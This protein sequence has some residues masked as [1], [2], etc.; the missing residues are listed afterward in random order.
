MDPRER[1]KCL[2]HLFEQAKRDELASAQASEDEEE[3]APKERARKGNRHR[4]GGSSSASLSSTGASP[5]ASTAPPQVATKSRIKRAESSPPTPSSLDDELKVGNRKES[6]QERQHGDR[7]PKG[8]SASSASPSSPQTTASSSASTA[9]L[10]PSRVEAKSRSKR[11]KSSPQLTRSASVASHVTVPSKQITASKAIGFASTSSSAPASLPIDADAPQPTVERH[12]VG[13]E[14]SHSLSA[15]LSSDRS[16]PE[17]LE[18]RLEEL[19]AF[20]RLFWRRMIIRQ[21]GARICLLVNAATG[22][23]IRSLSEVKGKAGILE[24]VGDA[25]KNALEQFGLLPSD[26]PKNWNRRWRDT[27]LFSEVPDIDILVDYVMLPGVS[28]VGRLRR[29]CEASTAP[30]EPP[31]APKKQSRRP[32]A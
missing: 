26:I 8:S 6:K 7:Q 10:P 18:S 24:S 9:P 15:P 27:R 31:T 23:N 1:V 20:R 14:R 19:R 21:L 13:S 28:D 29:L 17:N 4:H 12:V 5:L 22:Y 11:I 30:F 16:G 25:Y 3:P 32:R 2:E